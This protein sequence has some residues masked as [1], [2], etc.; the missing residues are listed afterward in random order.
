MNEFKGKVLFANLHPSGNLVAAKICFG[1]AEHCF[2]LCH[3]FDN[4]KSYGHKAHKL[5]FLKNLK[6]TEMQ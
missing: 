5:N 1:Q 6:K 4:L 2:T 3:K